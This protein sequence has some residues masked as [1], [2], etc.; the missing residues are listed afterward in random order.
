MSLSL[1][2]DI[3]GSTGRIPTPSRHAAVALQELY[4]L[5]LRPWEPSIF[6]GLLGSYIC[7][8][9]PIHLPVLRGSTPIPVFG[10]VTPSK[11][12]DLSQWTNS[13]PGGDTTSLFMGSG[14]TPHDSGVP[15]L[16]LASLAQFE[17]YLGQE[18]PRRAS[19]CRTDDDHARGINEL[20]AAMEEGNEARQAAAFADDS[21]K[22][23]KSKPTSQA[24]T[25]FQ[26]PT[27]ETDLSESP[28]RPEDRQ[29]SVSASDSASA[30]RNRSL[31]FSPPDS[32]ASPFVTASSST[33][34]AVSKTLSATS[35]VSHTTA[36]SQHLAGWN[37]AHPPTLLQ[38]PTAPFVPPPPMCMFFSP[39][40]KD[41][42]RGKVGV[43]KGELEVKGRGGGKFNILIVGEETTGHL[44]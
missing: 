15:D 5:T 8:T 25:T 4:S 34:S 36:I 13:T 38:M 6:A 12:H 37:R 21:T 27:P 1:L 31:T 43:W 28:A 35:S 24:N 3:T 16:S 14:L 32:M 20:L 2:P 22:A 44:W 39:A 26:V 42:Q 33:L 40:F 17:F 29:R 23:K 10:A 9:P 7:G 18:D 41:L 19:I 11:E 30:S